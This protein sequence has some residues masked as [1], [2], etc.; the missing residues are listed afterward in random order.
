LL[1]V[2]KAPAEEVNCIGGKIGN[3]AFGCC[4]SVKYDKRS[5]LCCGPD[6][7][8]PDSQVVDAT[9]GENSLCCGVGV[10]DRRVDG[11]CAGLPYN[12]AG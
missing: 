7:V 8:A 5:H 11:C 6:D 2:V 3:D 1:R 9:F 4:G 10:Y 12:L